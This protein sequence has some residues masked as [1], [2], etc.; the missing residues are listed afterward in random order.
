MYSTTCRQNLKKNEAEDKQTC[1]RNDNRR[2]G[3]LEADLN[4]VLSIFKSNQK[5]KQAILFGSSWNKFLRDI[6]IGL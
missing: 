6:I 2:Y 4:N 3:L 1:M 5:I